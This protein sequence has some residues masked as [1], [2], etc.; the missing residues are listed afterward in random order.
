MKWKIN[1]IRNSIIYV[2]K[3]VNRR[4]LFTYFYLNEN[5]KINSLGTMQLCLLPHL[6]ID[7]KWRKISA[8]LM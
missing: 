8:L 3:N 6:L 5:Q 1:Y 4:T 2:L 7:K